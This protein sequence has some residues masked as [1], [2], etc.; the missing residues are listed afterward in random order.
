[1]TGA[2]EVRI[3]QQPRTGG[4]FRGLPKE[5][6]M[7]KAACLGLM[8]LTLAGCAAGRTPAPAD[9]QRLPAAQ[10][11]H[12]TPAPPMPPPRTPDPAEEYGK[13]SGLGG[14]HDLFAQTFTADQSG[15]LSELQFAPEMLTSNPCD[16]TVEVRS[17]DDGAVPFAGDSPVLGRVVVKSADLPR[18]GAWNRPMLRI[19]LRAFHI[20]LKQGGRYAFAVFPSAHDA[21]VQYVVINGDV[22]KGGAL[23]TYL[24]SRWKTLSSTPDFQFRILA[25]PQET[26]GSSPQSRPATM[27][28]AHK[29]PAATQPATAII[30]AENEPQHGR[31]IAQAMP[32]PDSTRPPKK[33]V[34]KSTGQWQASAWAFQYQGQWYLQ[35]AV[36]NGTNSFRTRTI[37]PYSV[38]LRRQGQKMGTRIYPPQQKP[39][40]RGVY[41]PLYGQPAGST[42]GRPAM[43]GEGWIKQF[44]LS[45]DNKPLEPGIY[46]VTVS[47]PP[48]LMERTVETSFIVTAPP[49]P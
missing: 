12:F 27:R 19:D 18:S 34:I 37:R 41:Y 29:K 16:L 38:T 36:F 3:E 23:Y 5:L 43:P 47:F 14:G 9:S 24:Q 26:P 7:I 6:A 32:T 10:P 48:E 39:G 17:G 20:Q 2:A 49:I 8:M 13:P 15:L 45:P 28:L 25:Q 42:W 1:M 40:R 35:L 22:Y 31:I 46:H 21:Q 11:A 33:P 4:T 30:L 44:N